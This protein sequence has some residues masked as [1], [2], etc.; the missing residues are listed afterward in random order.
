MAA[1]TSEVTVLGVVCRRGQNG[2]YQIFLQ[3]QSRPGSPLA[4]VKGPI[5]NPPLPGTRIKVTGIVSK[6]DHGPL[7][8]IKSDQD[9]SLVSCQQG[10]LV[11][12]LLTSLLDRF[13]IKYDKALLEQNC[14][15]ESYSL[16]TLSMSSFIDLLSKSGVLNADVVVRERESIFASTLTRGLLDGVEKIKAP[17]QP[18]TKR[19]MPFTLDMWPT[20]VMEG[21]FPDYMK[22]TH[23]QEVHSKLDKK[24]YISD[25]VKHEGID[26]FFRCLSIYRND[27][28]IFNNWLQENKR[29]TTISSSFIKDKQKEGV[30]VFDS[31]SN[32]QLERFGLANVGKTLSRLGQMFEI[33]V[34]EGNKA[35]ISQGAYQSNSRIALLD[36]LPRTISPI[37][38]KINSDKLDKD[39]TLALTKFCEGKPLT[40]VSGSAG[41]GKSTLVA[42]MI[43]H[44]VEA[45]EHVVVVSL[46]GKAASRLN[47]SLEKEGLGFNVPEAQTIHGMFYQ[48]KKKVFNKSIHL[49]SLKPALDSTAVQAFPVR[50][51]RTLQNATFVN[52]KTKELRMPKTLIEE[53]APP[54]ILTGATIFIDESSQITSDLFALILEM[55]PK[56]I[57]MVGDDKQLRP[58]GAGRPFHDL[59]DLYNN[60]HYSDV[61]NYVEL[62]EDHRATKELAEFTK[63]VREGELPLGSVTTYDKDIDTPASIVDAVYFKEGSIIE[64]SDFTD[65]S[66][67]VE[68]ILHKEISKNSPFFQFSDSYTKSTPDANSINITLPCRVSTELSAK[69]ALLPDVILLAS[70]NSTVNELSE[71]VK[72]IL[73][74]YTT[75]NSLIKSLPIFSN[76]TANGHLPGDLVMQTSNANLRISYTTPEGAHV[77]AKTMNGET[78]VFV[79]A[80]AWLPLPSSKNTTDIEFAVNNAWDGCGLKDIAKNIDSKDPNQHLEL[81]KQLLLLSE[82]NKHAQSLLSM[83]LGE[84][85]LLPQHALREIKADVGSSIVCADSRIKRVPVLPGKPFSINNGLVNDSGSMGLVKDVWRIAEVHG[86]KPY[87]GRSDIEYPHYIYLSEQSS[88]MQG[89]FTSGNAFTSHKAQGSQAKMAISV[90]EPPINEEDSSNHEEGVYTGITRAESKSLVIVQDKSVSELNSIWK[91]TRDKEANKFSAIKA[92]ANGIISPLSDT[93]RMTTVATPHSKTYSLPINSREHVESNM[94]RI[95]VASM[96]LPSELNVFK[97][98]SG[99]ADL[100]TSLYPNDTTHHMSSVYPDAGR[101]MSLNTDALSLMNKRSFKWDRSMLTVLDKKVTPDVEL[102]LLLSD[103]LDTDNFDFS[104]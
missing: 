6:T 21:F 97:P 52:G 42:R 86:N 30:Q 54:A 72:N 29:A 14:Y 61:M 96:G 56:H 40:C 74:P 41:T 34:G 70:T 18:N 32:K 53:M 19:S 20:D 24:V 79:G 88:E 81:Y 85:L 102:D 47:I 33:N 25:F 23:G 43:S 12:D 50:V 73:R 58:V 27:P 100:F 9:I 31:A 67:L 4:Y 28:S 68:A 91:N 11:R 103:V 92:I 51:E 49:N 35:L 2:K 3:V 1:H 36:K 37:K 10:V 57:V 101:L 16:S 26:S 17:Y 7:M 38:V 104:F 64:C 98:E 8:Q 99:V 80:N 94:R 55:R 78:Y 76:F 69:K 46:A 15:S 75:P 13:D 45:G 63:K 22:T 84:V 60:G 66:N 77:S 44:A 48:G 87:V 62:T 82:T 90:V 83:A 71:K 39:Q 93:L 65:S 95:A 59:I 5:D 89:S